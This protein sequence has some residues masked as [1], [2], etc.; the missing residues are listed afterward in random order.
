MDTPTVVTTLRLPDDL[1]HASKIE[2]VTK[3]MSLND[4]FVEAISKA[5]PV[6]KKT[7]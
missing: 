2:A 4:F 5:V 1:H 7:K 6:S 3:R